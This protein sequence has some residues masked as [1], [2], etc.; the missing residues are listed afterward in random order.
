[1]TGWGGCGARLESL[2][3]DAQLLRLLALGQPRLLVAPLPLALLGG[4]RR[5][6]LALLVRHR[7]EPRLVADIELRLPRGQAKRCRGRAP[8]ARR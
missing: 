6:Q 5:T 1:M 7:R 4:G 3:L 2:G 8:A